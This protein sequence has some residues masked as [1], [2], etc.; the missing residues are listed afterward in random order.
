MSRRQRTG[1]ASIRAPPPPHWLP[2]TGEHERHY[3]CNDTCWMEEHMLEQQHLDVEQ[4][5]DE[6]Q[7]LASSPGP[8]VGGSPG[9]VHKSAGSGRS[10][11][12]SARVAGSGSKKKVLQPLAELLPA[13]AAAELVQPG[14]ASQAQSCQVQLKQLHNTMQ[15]RWTRIRTRRRNRIRIR[16]RKRVQKTSA[17]PLAELKHQWS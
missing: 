7:H 10:K 15:R 8:A 3:Q 5:V 2:D 11:S 1:P 13:Q 9:S 12:T 4:H 14:P 17:Q 6:E 16:T